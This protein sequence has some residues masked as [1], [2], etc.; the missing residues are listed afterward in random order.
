MLNFT[1]PII[2]QKLSFIILTYK[3]ADL[4]KKCI[5]SIIEFNHKLDYEFIIVN[6]DDEQKNQV[7][8]IFKDIKNTK[9]LNP[10]Y[11]TYFAWWI[12]LWLK[13]ATWDYVAFINDDW[14][15]VDNSLEKMYNFIIRNNNEYFAVTWNI[16]NDDKNKT[17]TNTATKSPSVLAEISRTTFIW[18]LFK[19]FNYFPQ[20]YK[21]FKILWWDR[22][23]EDR[24]I[25]CWCDAFIIL[26]KKEFIDNW[27][28]YKN[29]RL[30]YTEENIWEIAKKIDK[31]IMYLHDTKM[32]HNWNYATKKQPSSKILAVTIS[33]RFNYFKKFHWSIKAYFVTIFSVV[34]NPYILFR[35]FWIIKWLFVLKK[36]RKN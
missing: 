24:N 29:L 17:L 20:Y 2:M 30:Y 1:R 14:Y 12:N 28:F 4:L 26:N 25:E 5:E 9:I 36:E 3:S 6:N 11:N 19:I 18:R 10:W 13:E 33:D 27:S 34:W 31:K 15:F 21:E 22:E 35:L 32:I 8:D 16:Y 23:K 7:E